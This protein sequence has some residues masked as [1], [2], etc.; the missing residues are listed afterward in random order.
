MKCCM[1]RKN[2]EVFTKDNNKDHKKAYVKSIS[3]FYNIRNNLLIYYGRRFSVLIR[4]NEEFN[5]K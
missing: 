2:R 5:C 1:N 3:M 4:S